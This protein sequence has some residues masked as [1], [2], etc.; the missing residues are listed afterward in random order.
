[1]FEMVKEGGL[2]AGDLGV[3]VAHATQRNAGLLVFV[4]LRLGEVKN[5]V[6]AKIENGVLVLTFG[7]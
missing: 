7:E 3:M 4:E 1:M 5:I 6:S 2:N